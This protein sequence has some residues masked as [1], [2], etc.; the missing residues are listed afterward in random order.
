MNQAIGVTLSKKDL[1]RAFDIIDKTKCGR[2]RLEEVKTISSLISNDTEEEEEEEMSEGDQ[3]A[4][5]NSELVELYE[6]VK[7]KLER[8]NTTLE[9]IVYEQL[10]YLPSQFANTKGIQ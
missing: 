10:K 4:K 9:N 5:V 3:Q 2:I 1:K 7:E 6:Q 8:K